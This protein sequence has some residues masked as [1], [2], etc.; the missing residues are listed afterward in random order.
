MSPQTLQVHL[1]INHHHHHCLDSMGG[2][3]L[4]LLSPDALDYIV[5]PWS[6]STKDS[7]KNCVLILNE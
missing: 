1:F 3:I 6:L 4:L 2:F 5:S 7:I